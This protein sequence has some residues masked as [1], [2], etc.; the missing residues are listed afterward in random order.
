MSKRNIIRI[1]RS[2]IWP[3]VFSGFVFPGMGQVLNGEFAKGGFL[4]AATFGTLY[5]FFKVVGDRLALI[6]PEGARD[7]FEN[8]TAYKTQIIQLFQ[9][10]PDWFLIFYLLV[11]SIVGYSVVDAYLTAKQKN[12]Y[13]TAKKDS[14]DESDSDR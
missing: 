11:F 7:W 5:W 6:S 8:T 1:A 14:V 9:E 13:P 12:R 2:P 4:M 3:A 10:T